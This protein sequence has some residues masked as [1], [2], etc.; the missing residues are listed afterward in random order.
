MLTGMLHDGTVGLEC[1][2]RCGEVAIVQDPQETE[3][4]NMPET[5]P[6]NVDYVVSLV[7]M[8]PLLIEL[9]VDTVSDHTVRTTIPLNL[10][11][12]DSIAERVV[13]IVAEVDQIG[14]LVSITHPNC[15]GNLWELNEGKVLRYRCH[16]GHAFT[17]DALLRHSQQP[18]E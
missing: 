3:H 5:T 18:L 16:T 7:L 11:R 12:E 13:S 6:R 10:K 14:H 9:T 15:D 17:A 1:V 4:P 2:K 8:E